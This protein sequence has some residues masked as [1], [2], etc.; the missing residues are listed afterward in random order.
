M[1]EL[2]CMPRRQNRGVFST[3]PRN[4]SGNEDF[5]W[6]REKNTGS[7]GHFLSGAI[8]MREKTESMNLELEAR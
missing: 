5:L 1:P 8:Y 4:S 7:T 2:I 6:V 3:I